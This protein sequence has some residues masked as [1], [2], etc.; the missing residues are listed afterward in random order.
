MRGPFPLP[1]LCVQ[2]GIP[3][4][5]GS[6][7]SWGGALPSHSPA[8]SVSQLSKQETDRDFSL[9]WEAGRS[10]PNTLIGSTDNFTSW[11]YFCTPSF[12]AGH[13]LSYRPFP[14]LMVKMRFVILLRRLVSSHPFP[15]P[16]PI[17][18]LHCQHSPHCHSH[19]LIPPEPPAVP[20]PHFTCL[21][22]LV[23]LSSRK[24]LNSRYL[25]S[26]GPHL[27]LTV[28]QPSKPASHTWIPAVTTVLCANVE[29]SRQSASACC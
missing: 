27:L 7:G 25:Q 10:K 9:T 20:H 15:F 6:L 22:I 18:P 14:K 11:V 29:F 12:M 5:G 21:W 23:F 1:E 17:M 24:M 26:Q 8:P 19:L 16:S 2:V 28:C 13:A 4:D 3:T